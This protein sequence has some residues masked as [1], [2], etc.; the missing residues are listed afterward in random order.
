M[1]IPNYGALILMATSVIMNIDILLGQL[2]RSVRTML[3]NTDVKFLSPRGLR[4][5]ANRRIGSVDNDYLSI[6][7]C[8]CT[9]NKR[10]LSEQLTAL[11]ASFAY[12]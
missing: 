4:L 11:T 9:Y 8:D 5:F 3:T 12:L 6:L 2:S 10:S 1:C 7:H